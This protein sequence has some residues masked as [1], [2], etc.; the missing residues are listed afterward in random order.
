MDFHNQT[1][2]AAGIARSELLYKDLLLATVAIKGTW[3]ADPASGE[4]RLLEEQ[5]EV[6]EA[7][8]ETPFGPLDLDLMPIKSAC[9][10]AI[11][12]NAHAPSS[13]R[14]VDSMRVGIRVGSFQRS[15]AVFGER[16]W[17]KRGG[18]LAISH[19]KPFS[20]MPITWENSFGG[21]A[22]DEGGNA[23]SYADNPD[24]KG[25]VTIEENVPGTPLPNI[26]EAD[27]LITDWRQH[28][29]PAALT[30]V[31]RTSALRGTRGIHADLEQQRTSLDPSAFTFSHPRMM[32]PRYPSGER[33][34]LDGMTP[35][36]RWDVQLPR[37]DASIVVAL[38][39]ASYVLP[40]VPDTVVLY[41][42][43]RRICVI[44]RRAIVY[45]FA[46]ER[47]RSIRVVQGDTPG[48]H[49][50]TTTITEQKS[51]QEPVVLLGPACDPEVLP[52]PFS[53]ILEH[54][55]LTT[56]LEGLPLCPSGR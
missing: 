27:Q 42:E 56:I 10:F 28:P 36:G 23:V 19:P 48:S 15:I 46:P 8:A 29:M 55:P 2:L 47:L 7:D 45:E 25:F 40:L 38:G 37:I 49:R 53:V 9:D 13:R 17:E 41:P 30:A 12:G 32:L 11:Y 34:E 1:P 4:L 50:R 20:Q 44:A 16:I 52:I 6:A 54:Y 22:L 39:D 26:E 14:T 3:E 24:G 5:P 21:A 51:A 43:D 33:V 35:A 18:A 31:K